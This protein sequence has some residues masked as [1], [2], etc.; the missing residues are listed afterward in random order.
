MLLLFAGVLRFRKES[1]ESS[2]YVICS[3]G[4][5]KQQWAETD[6]SVSKDIYDLMIWQPD[7]REDK[8]LNLPQ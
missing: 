1:K 7:F 3:D 2:W 6:L 4:I 8:A 5:M